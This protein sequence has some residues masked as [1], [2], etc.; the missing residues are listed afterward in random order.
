MAISLEKGIHPSH[1]K[2]GSG[3][4]VGTAPVVESPKFCDNKS[5]GMLVFKDT[6]PGKDP[7]MLLIQ[8]MKTPFGFAPPAGHV[9]GDPTY[10]A[11]GSRELSEEVGLEAGVMVEVVR[12]R[13]GNPCRRENGDHHRWKVYSVEATGE[14]ERSLE[15]TRSA[16]WYS[17]SDIEQLA[18]KTEDYRRGDVSDGEWEESPG[19]EEVWYELFQQTGILEDPTHSQRQ[20]IPDFLHGRTPLA[21]RYYGEQ[22]KKTQAAAHAFASIG[23]ETYPKPDAESITI[24]SDDG[25]TFSFLGGDQL[26]VKPYQAQLGFFREIKAQ[27]DIPMVNNFMYVAIQDGYLVRTASIEVAY[28]MATGKMIIF[29]EFPT[30]F[31]HELPPEIVSVVQENFDRYPQ[32]PIEDIPTKIDDVKRQ[33]I[34]KPIATDE[35][36][37]VIFSSILKL[38]KDLD[39][40]FTPRN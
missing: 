23:I 26:V 5:V 13:K 33:E 34:D 10:E 8:R 21:G 4:E 36:K 7:K 9:D 27:Q 1:T 32:L 19:L 14:V 29:S 17:K 6:A 18:Q 11:A 15:E 25:D 30:R 40:K 20:R 22:Y 39:D 37:G 35:Q 16:G 38:I 28:A 2:K 31:S 12:A 3:T 24:Q